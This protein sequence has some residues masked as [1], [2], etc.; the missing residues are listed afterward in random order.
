[1]PSP[2]SSSLHNNRQY[3]QKLLVTERGEAWRA[4]TKLDECFQ[5][6][7]ARGDEVELRQA[8]ARAAAF[9]P[10]QNLAHWLREAWGYHLDP[11]RG[12]ALAAWL[13]TQKR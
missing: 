10:A 13:S 1:M 12:A 11:T 2:V 7:R 8:V 6:A 9:A 4:E 5:P 3:L